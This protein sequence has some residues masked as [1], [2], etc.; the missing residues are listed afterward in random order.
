MI[1]LLMCCCPTYATLWV[2]AGAPGAALAFV[3]GKGASGVA[4]TAARGDTQQSKNAQAA[5]LARTELG[6][7]ATWVRGSGV[8]FTPLMIARSRHQAAML[9]RADPFVLNPRTQP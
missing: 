7:R 1:P 4:A 9:D 5:W 6:K 2:G 8:P 3:P